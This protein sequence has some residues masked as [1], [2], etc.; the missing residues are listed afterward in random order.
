MKDPIR[1]LPRVINTAMI[2]VI[3]GFVLMNMALYIAVPIQHMRETSTPVV[4]G[5]FYFYS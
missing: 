4:V 3:V 2:I 1:D 5:D